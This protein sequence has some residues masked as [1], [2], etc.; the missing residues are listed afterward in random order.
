V[1]DYDHYKESRDR[2]MDLLSNV[3]EKFDVCRQVSDSDDNL[4]QRLV[5]L[6]VCTLS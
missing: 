6:Q 1:L 5:D 2:C 4:Q 3:S